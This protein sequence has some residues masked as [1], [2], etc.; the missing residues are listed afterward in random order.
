MPPGWIFDN[1]LE[2]L[3]AGLQAD[4][5]L[6]ADKLLE[7]RT[8][9]N[10]GYLDFREMRTEELAALERSV[11]RVYDNFKSEGASSFTDPT[12]FEGYMAQLLSFR[13]MLATRLRERVTATDTGS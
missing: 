1:V 13:K 6:L 12:F 11:A 10:G 8:E 7:G 3:A 9:E 2:R 5:P 4:W